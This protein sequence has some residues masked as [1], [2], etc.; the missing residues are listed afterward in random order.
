MQRSLKQSCLFALS[1]SLLF[2][3]ISFAQSKQ[4]P[5]QRWEY[6]T[7]QLCFEYR[8]QLN[9]YGD[10]GWELVAVFGEQNGNCGSYTF[11][12]L[13]PANAPKYVDP[14]ERPK[15][16]ENAPTCN[17]T[18]AAAPTIRG[19]RLG[20][21][22]EELIE[23]FPGANPNELKLRRERATGYSSFGQFSFTFGGAQHKD[24]LDNFHFEIMLFDNQVRSFRV[25][26]PFSN[27]VYY[28]RIHS[29]EQLIEKLAESF[30]LPPKENWRSDYSGQVSLRCQ[31]FKLEA[32][33]QSGISL[34]VEDISPTMAEKIKQRQQEDAAKKRTDFKP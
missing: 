11:K 33:L 8:E 20:M 5:A 16:P 30:R 1:L 18:F 27:S 3:S 21:T 23:L 29:D 28:G 22:V 34:Y 14:N 24:R 26:Y 17:L 9:K 25:Q 31:G 4:P 7:V 2:T 19:L 12:R 13:K 6:L 10:D 15:P 32:N